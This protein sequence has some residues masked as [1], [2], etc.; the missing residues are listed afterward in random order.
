[1]LM[2]VREPEPPEVRPRTSFALR[3]RE[4]PGLL[5][6]DRELLR[7]YLAC[8]AAALGTLAVPFYILYA[9]RTIGLSGTNLG[10]LSTAFLLSQT[11]TNLIWG[12]IADR[13][14]NRIVF[15]LSIGVWA[16]S[17]VALMEA[18]SLWALAAVF[19]GLGAGQGGFQNSTQNMILEFGSREDLPMRIAMMNTA[20]SFMNAAG[21]LLGGLIAHGVSFIAVF[22][23]STLMLVAA[24]A[25]VFF[26]VNEPRRRNLYR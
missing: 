2:M 21:P 9:G 10:V 13:I 5:R 18:H 4:I 17:T 12:A 22:W 3:M 20:I 1:M 23:V 25:T 24:F 6:D 7:F 11:G 8:S 16:I 26:F 19:A 14:G 15:L